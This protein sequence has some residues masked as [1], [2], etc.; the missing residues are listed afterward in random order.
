MNTS[1]TIIN[2]L[3]VGETCPSYFYSQIAQFSVLKAASAMNFYFVILAEIF[4]AKRCICVCPCVFTLLTLL[5]TLFCTFSYL[6]RLLVD[7]A[8]SVFLILCKMSFSRALLVETEASK[9]LLVK[10]ALPWTI[11]YIAIFRFKFIWNLCSDDCNCW[12]KSYV[13]FKFG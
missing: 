6:P 3:L 13:H 4:K 8:M 12:V 7:Q 1:I 11:F 9:H 5:D 10:S 2:T